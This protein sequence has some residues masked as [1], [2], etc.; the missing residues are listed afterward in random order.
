MLT[1]HDTI[2]GSRQLAEAAKRVLPR[3]EVSIA[4]EYSTDLATSSPPSSTA[5]S[6]AGRSTPFSA[7]RAIATPSC[8]CRIPM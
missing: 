5:K 2:A 1:D 8:C 4:A 6:R 7:K 3:L